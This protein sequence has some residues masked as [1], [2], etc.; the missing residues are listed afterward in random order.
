MEE[1]I[2]ITC[3]SCKS[4]RCLIGRL[5]T[6]G[7]DTNFDGKFYP[8][9]IKVPFLAW[10]RPNV[11]L[12]KH[13]EFKACTECGH[14]WSSVN[15]DELKESLEKCDWDGKPQIKPA[16]RKSYFGVISSAIIAA[17]LLIIVFFNYTT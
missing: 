15:P 7:V 16:E 10:E 6:L 8:S 4:T 1:Q 17:L 5:D 14:L 12:E 13:D 9:H 2:N 3:P 11:V